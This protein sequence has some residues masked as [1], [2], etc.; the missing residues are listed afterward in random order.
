M[1]TAAR[2][3]LLAGSVLLAAP[4]H[5]FSDD[6]ARKAILDLRTTVNSLRDQIGAAQRTIMDQ[7]NRMDQLQ[8]DNAQLRGQ[9]EDLTN[10][11]TTLQITQKDYY[12]DL[13]RRLK[14]FEPQQ[15]TIDGVQGVVQPGETDAFNKALQQFRDGNY[16]S[17][18]AA[19][20][21]FLKRYPQSPYA[22]TAH[23]WLGNAYYA[24]RDYARSQAELNGVV[25]NY[26]THPRAPE[27]LLSIANN[28]A[29]QGQKSAERQTLQR[30]VSQYPDSPAARNAQERLGKLK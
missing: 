4:A 28:Q 27:A 1:V 13:D 30:V 15:E 19:F 12:A 11:V 25:K 3:A 24:Q 10:Q 22:P 26:P 5:A 6:E 16:K 2:A 14:K 7:A 21:D 29:D 23:Y 18:G 20:A 17:A 8:R 9:T